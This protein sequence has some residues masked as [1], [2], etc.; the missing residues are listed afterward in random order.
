MFE[1]KL[2]DMKSLIFISPDMF[3]TL[4]A[5]NVGVSSDVVK[6]NWSEY[7]YLGALK[8]IK[9]IDAALLSCPKYLRKSVISE[10]NGF[11]LSFGP[12]MEEIC[13]II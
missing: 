1:Q 8:A 7:S 11:V 4:T 13:P 3:Q 12:D 9:E 6:E 10:R 2:E 5:S